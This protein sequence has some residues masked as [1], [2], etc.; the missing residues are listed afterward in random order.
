MVDLVQP[1]SDTHVRVP[2]MRIQ[3][4]HRCGRLQPVVPDLKRGERGQHVRRPNTELDRPNAAHTLRVLAFWRSA[5]RA[6]RG[7]HSTTRVP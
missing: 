7:R 3:L 5:G 1:L 2:G 4:V 6:Q